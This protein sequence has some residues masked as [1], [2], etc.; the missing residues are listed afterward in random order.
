MKR[1]TRLDPFSAALLSALGAAQVVA[2]GGTA[3][4]RGSDGGAGPAGAAGGGTAGVAQGGS[5]G[6]AVNRFPC[7]NPRDLGGGLIQCDGFRHRETSG[8]CPSKVPRSDQHLAISP[9]AECKT[10]ADCT[11][12]P[13]GVC[14]A[15]GQPQGIG[16]SS[17]VSV[18]VGPFCSYGCA[19]DRDCAANELCQCGDPVGFCTPAHCKTDADCNPGFLCAGHITQGCDGNTTYTCQSPG[20]GGGNGGRGGGDSCGSD[21]D[22]TNAGN[23][24]LF[25]PRS[26]LVA[27]SQIFCNM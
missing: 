25:D 16:G 5:G 6:G 20:L 27:C 2:C 9:T 14:Q 15:A 19:Q 26:Q 3:L 12:K 4:S 10:D 7:N 23:R 8:T 1:R 17:G 11:A 22:C 13:Y 24:C 21:A 18:P